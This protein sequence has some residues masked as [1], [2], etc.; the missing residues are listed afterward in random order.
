M[1]GKLL[2]PTDVAEKLNYS[3]ATVYRLIDSGQLQVVK[4]SRGLRVREADLD[5]LIRLNT[6]N[7]GTLKRNWKT[8]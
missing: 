1:D 4:I 6:E 8:G 5:R 2:K 3:L 7:R